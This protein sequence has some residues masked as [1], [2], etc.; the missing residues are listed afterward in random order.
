MKRLVI[1]ILLGIFVLTACSP[2]AQESLT[3][4]VE[5]SESYVLPGFAFSINYPAGWQ[6][7]TRGTFTVITELEEDHQNAFDNDYAPKGYEVALD[8]V[9][10][11][12]LRDRGLPSDPSLE[13][14]FNFNMEFFGVQ[15][16]TEVSQIVVFGVPA[17]SAKFQIDER[18]GLVSTGFLEQR[19]FVLVIS[20]PS[21]DALAEFAP[22]WARIL[23]N[24]KPVAE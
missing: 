11:S 20:A 21:E 24:I 5:L 16:P 3:P 1:D 8:H 19:V 18:W 2:A 12:F 15:E 23:E 10:L 4:D 22:T 13:D 14:L 9:A 7:D 17:M 6:A